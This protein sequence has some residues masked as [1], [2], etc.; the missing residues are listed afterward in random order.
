MDWAESF[1]NSQEPDTKPY[2]NEGIV[3]RQKVEQGD[4]ASLEDTLALLDENKILHAG[5]G[6]NVN[7]AY[8]A[9]RLEKDGI[10]VAIISV[11][12][13]EF[14]MA[15]E[16]T[17]GSAGYEPRLLLKQIKEEKK[18]ADFVVVVFH[19]GNEFNPL[20]SPDT[21]A[22]YRLVCDM[23][24]D[25]VIGGHTHCPQGY[26]YYGGK[27]IVY[28][29]GNLL[30][31]NVNKSN[32]NCG[33]SQPYLLDFFHKVSMIKISVPMLRYD[34]LI[35]LNQGFDQFNLS[36]FHSMIINQSDRL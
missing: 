36:W 22:R 5:A 6:A 14:G 25:A 32:P 30:F 8:Q 1:F 2:L 4:G 19:G 7:E 33:I 28:S 3:A 15:T 13:N 27:P 29:L 10:S 9:L 16:T 23:G 26:E 17:Y 21:V 35:L 12:E 34:L 24:A 20:P 11:C 31:Q 18:R